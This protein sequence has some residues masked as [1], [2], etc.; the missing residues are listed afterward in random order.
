MKLLFAVCVI[1]PSVAVA[2][3]STVDRRAQFEKAMAAA[4]AKVTASTTTQ[5]RLIKQYLAGKK[6]KAQAVQLEHDAFW[7]SPEHEDE[8]VAAERA[9]EGCQLCWGGRPCALLA[10]NDDIVEGEL[11]LKDMPRLNYAGEFDVLQIPIIRLTTRRRADVQNYDKAMAPK[12]MAIHP[13]G[14]VFIS[15]GDAS[16]IDAQASALS[17]CN[18]DP[19]RNHR[20]GDCYVYAV[21]NNVVIS[22]R[23]MTPK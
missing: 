11:A 14:R 23:R 3:L 12:A 16:P 4:L 22:E 13:W 18:N 21:G 15:A 20:D 19:T 6:N 8:E 17:K 5:E 2:A 7:F 9:L 1:V 10:V